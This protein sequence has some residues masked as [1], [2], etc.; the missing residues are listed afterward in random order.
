MTLGETVRD[1]RAHFVMDA[2]D[3]RRR[4]Q[5]MAQGKNAIWRKTL[6]RRPF[7][8]Q[9]TDWY[10]V[11][12]FDLRICSDK[13]IA[14]TVIRP[15]DDLTYRVRSAFTHLGL[16]QKFYFT[17]SKS[18]SIR[19]SARP[20]HLRRSPIDPGHKYCS[21]SYRFVEQQKKAIHLYVSRFRQPQLNEESVT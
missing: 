6:N 11:S 21:R 20:T 15:L 7:F 16:W 14:I 1:I 3:E 19:L 4:T 18:V 2:D 12:L 17:G 5:V 9:C 10:I 13:V 8:A